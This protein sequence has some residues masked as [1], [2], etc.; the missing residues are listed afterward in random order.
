MK[1]VTLFTSFKLIF[2]SALFGIMPH[3]Y[4]VN[5]VEMDDTSQDS[6]LQYQAFT[7]SSESWSEPKAL[8]PLNAPSRSLLIAFCANVSPIS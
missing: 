2:G 5:L 4:A 8:I 3:Y 6:L 1:Q 7:G